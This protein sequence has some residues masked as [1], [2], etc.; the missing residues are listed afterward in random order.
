MGENAGEIKKMYLYI[1]YGIY[2]RNGLNHAHFHSVNTWVTK[3]VS[4]VL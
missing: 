4:G 1:D 2:M 3:M